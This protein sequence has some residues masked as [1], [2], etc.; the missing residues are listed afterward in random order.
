VN[1]KVPVSQ[2]IS[3]SPLGVIS[4]TSGNS[5][6]IYT[7]SKEPE[8]AVPSQQEASIFTPAVPGFILDVAKS[9]TPFEDVSISMRER[10]KAKYAIDINA[11]L[12]HPALAGNRGLSELWGYL[13]RKLPPPPPPLSIRQEERNLSSF[14]RLQA[15]RACH[16][17]PL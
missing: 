11:N 14:L 3:W 13:S 7:H 6:S 12:T 16:K 1:V 15:A 4:T 10:A 2:N 8:S 9:A 5:I 17:T